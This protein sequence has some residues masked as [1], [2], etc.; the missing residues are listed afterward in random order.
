MVLDRDLRYIVLNK[1]GLPPEMHTPR[2]CNYGW[3]DPAEV[4]PKEHRHML[5]KESLSNSYHVLRGCTHFL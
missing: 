5:R 4:T 1:E 3:R 2:Q